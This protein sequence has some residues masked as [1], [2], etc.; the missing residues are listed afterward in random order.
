MFYSGINTMLN[1][2]IQKE[3][4]FLVD[5]LTSIFGFFMN[6][7]YNIVSV[8]IS[9]GTLGLTIIILT[10][11]VR[12]LMLPMAMK[13][14]KS[15]LKMQSLTPQIESIKQKYGNTKD[16]ELSRKMNVE[17]Q[18]VYTKN[19]VNP[20][21]GCL[22][23]FIQLPMFIA[24]SYVMNQPYLFINK[25]GV[26]YENLSTT[27]MSVPNYLNDNSPFFEMAKSKVPKGM[28]I[29]LKVTEDVQKVLNKLTNAEWETIL[30][31]VPKDVEV[32]LLDG[33]SQLQNIEFF[34][35]IDLTAPCGWS[36]PGVIIP[37]LAAGTTFLSTYLAMKKQ[38]KSD[39][40]TL[41]TQQ[42]VMMYGMPIFMGFVTAGLMAGVGLY[43]I[44]SNIFQIGQQVVI[45]KSINEE[46]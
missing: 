28:T 38:P 46:E 37:I 18:E 34:M 25:I 14:Q 31:A 6:I 8:I 21:A 19:G 43:W 32:T 16:P 22:P 24:L 5:I 29:D 17:I 40:P 36:L 42:K 10:I 9:N 23:I 7:I 35:G 3:P 44:T 2:L 39:N 15:M 12:F 27:I 26:V 4:W 13:Q 33:L 45:N 11:F 1:G 41:Q 20:F 30:N